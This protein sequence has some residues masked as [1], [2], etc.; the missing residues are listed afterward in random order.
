MAQQVFENTKLFA[1]Q[2]EAVIALPDDSRRGIQLQIPVAQQWRAYLHIS[3]QQGTYASSQF[4]EVKRLH[5]VVVRAEIKPD[6]S[7]AGVAAS[8]QHQNKQFRSAGTHAA[9]YLQPIHP[10]QI[11]V[12]YQQVVIVDLGIFPALHAVASDING[13][14][15]MA[16][17]LCQSMRE[18]IFILYQ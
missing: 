13:V 14:T 5:H 8:G 10:W 9:A 18:V 12:Q 7:F 6:D 11:E 15:L 16:K 2:F 3:S 4:G 1:G 17:A